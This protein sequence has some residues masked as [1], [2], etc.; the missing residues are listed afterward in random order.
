MQT[1]TQRL[2][3]AGS[4]NAADRPGRR[5]SAYLMITLAMTCTMV[6]GFSMTY[7]GPMA[8]GVYPEVSPLVH[9]HGWTFIAWYLLLPLQAGLIRIRRVR[10]HRNLG[11][12]SLGLGALM[13]AVGLVVSLVQ[14]DKASAPDGDP[15]WQLMGVPIFGVWV[16]F[17]MFYVEAMR[18]RRRIEEHKRFIILASAVALSAGTFRIVVRIAG[19]S[20]W[21]SAIGMIVCVVFPLIAMIDDR[22]KRRAIHPIY[23]WGAVA[24]VLVIGGTFL[25]GATPAGATV[26]AGLA[27]AGRLVRPLYPEP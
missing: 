14:I 6:L 2:H 18:R 26:E 12:A 21:L 7:F 1:T 23:G 20:A 27:W 4:Q 8:R 19:F 24:I 22:R 9:V 16:L 10:V 15:F 3:T 5:D 13:V 25:L 11:L 17:T